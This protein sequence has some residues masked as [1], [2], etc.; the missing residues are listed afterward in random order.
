MALKAVVANL[1]AVDEAHRS[2][3]VEQD[4]KFVLDLDGESVKDHPSTGPLT[5]ALEREKEAKKTAEKELGKLKGDYEKFKD[6]DPDKARE[7]L[8]KI[9]ELEDAK[10]ID[11]GQIDEL[12][13][14]RTERMRSEFEAKSQATQTT[15]DELTNQNKALTGRLESLI[16]FSAVKDEAVK[17]GARPGALTDIENRA[18]GVWRLGENEKPMA[19]KPGTEDEPMYGAKGE[20]ITIPEWIGNLAKESDYLFEPNRGGGAG[21]SGGTQTGGTKTI[22]RHS[23]GSHLEAIA[24]GEATIGD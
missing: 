17:A 4:G 3:Y 19:I 11:A 13:E 18:R 14:Q 20:P 10:L 7:A 12:V 9:Q 21:G 5:R 23:A 22:S 1:D 16:I 24:A 2:L 15:I 8:S 6:I